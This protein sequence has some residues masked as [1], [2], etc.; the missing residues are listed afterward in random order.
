GIFPLAG[1]FSKDLILEVAMIQHNYI[2]YSVLLFTAGLTA[3]YSF[4][5]VALIFHGEERY[6]L[7]GFHPHEAY[8][9]ML[10]A[11][12]PLL[13]LAI[14]AG[15]FKMT[16][17]EM[18]TYVLPA[19]EYHVHNP[20][21]YWIMT[22]GTQ[23]FVIIAIYFAY[24]IYMSKDVKVPDGTSKMENSFGYKLLINQYYIPYF[25]E[26]Y[27]V[28]PYRELSALCWTKIDQKIVDASVDGIANAFYK[29]GEN[30]R[31]MQSGNL[32]TMLKWMVAGTVALLS[33]AVVF[34]LAA[35]H[36]DEI[37]AILSA[38]GV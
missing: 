11:M 31:T 7:F 10:I 22:V 15:A 24:K 25:Y 38:I 3:F 8:K 35:R 20:A 14:I 33:L 29:T 19:T 2:I 6:K 36:S 1:F 21:V 28:K 27:F 30:T 4:R 26:E 17:F 13:L 16:Y 9:F 23:I 18:V 12:S 5:I 32:S 37:K 34:G